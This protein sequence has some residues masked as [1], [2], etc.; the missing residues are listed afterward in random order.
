MTI[1]NQNQSTRTFS[2]TLAVCALVCA[3]APTSYSAAIIEEIIWGGTTDLNWNTNT[4]WGGGDIPNI[5]TDHAKFTGT[6]AGTVAVSGG[7]NAHSIAFS[8]ANPYIIRTDFGLTLNGTGIEADLLISNTSNQT[9]TIRVGNNDFA[10]EKGTVQGVT[11]EGIAVSESDYGS[12]LTFDD[13][14]STTTNGHSIVMRNATQGG[15]G[16]LT[17]TGTSSITNLATAGGARGRLQVSDTRAITGGSI[18]NTGGES[19]FG[20]GNLTTVTLTDVAVTNTADATPTSG[21][22]RIDGDVTLAGTTTITNLANAGGAQ[23]YTEFVNGSSLIGGT[24]ANTGGYTELDAVG[25]SLTNV[26]VTNA[27]DANGTVGYLSHIGNFDVLNLN[28]TSSITNTADAAG[29]RAYTEIGGSAEISSGPVTNMG[30]YTKVNG[31]VV[32][33]NVTL[34]NRI[35]GN[36]LPGYLAARFASTFPGTTTVGFDVNAT[37]AAFAIVSNGATLTLPGNTVTLYVDTSATYA[38]AVRTLIWGETGNATLTAPTTVVVKDL[39]GATLTNITTTIDTV[40]R[41]ATTSTTIGATEVYNGALQ[42][43]L[44]ITL[45]T[46]LSEA[47]QHAVRSVAAGAQ[48]IVSKSRHAVHNVIRNMTTFFRLEGKMAPEIGDSFTRLERASFQAPSLDGS[49]FLNATEGMMNATTQQTARMLAPLRTEK[50]G[51]W[52]QPFGQYVEEGASSTGTGHKSKTA[53]LLFGIDHKI[54]ANTLI[55]AAIGSAQSTAETNDGSKA[56]IKDKFITL[57][58]TWAKDQWFVET[59]LSFSHNRFRASRKI[60]ANTLANNTHNGYQLMPSIG[61]GRLIKLNE[62]WSLTPNA[63]ATLLYGREK[64]YREENAGANNNLTVTDRCSSQLRTQ[65]GSDFTY[66]RTHNFGQGTYG[67]GLSM[68]IEDPL[69]KGNIN[70]TISGATGS[71]FSVS[72]NQKTTMKGALNLSS[73]WALHTLWDLNLNYAG[74][75]GN[76]YHAHEV[77]FKLRR[78]F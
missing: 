5:A 25:S 69:K 78:K 20:D 66:S 73:N 44:K 75:F 28:G 45:N 43:L 74:E 64:G 47:S 54:S 38:N 14:I 23:G 36:G 11:L 21:R 57:F 30:G 18:A 40:T 10:L 65:F 77:A 37:T 49:S 50:S 63:S 34:R 41:T 31:G 53:G 24:L 29:N 48:N 71:N 2:L 15:A 58:S 76:R 27:V 67:I 4:N 55:G 17:L 32:L 62:A 46:R 7:I 16:T 26:T 35:D 6:N 68:I 19:F 60:N 56:L 52:F 70:G 12:S 9:Q 42:S 51:I 61:G 13:V 3:S 1:Q 39:A 72:T 22:T 59:L 33:R 8:G